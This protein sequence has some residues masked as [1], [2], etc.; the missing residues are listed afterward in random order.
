MTD[1]SELEKLHN[2]QNIF[3]KVGLPIRQKNNQ[4]TIFVKGTCPGLK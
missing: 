2:E 4:E 1:T 3:H